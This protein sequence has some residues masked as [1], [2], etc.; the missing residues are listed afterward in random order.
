MP[1]KVKRHKVTQPD[2]P[3]IRYIA[4]T[5]GQVTT[6]DADLYD[7]LIQWNWFAVWDHTTQSFY[8]T[9]KAIVDGKRINLGMHAAIVQPAKGFLPD[10]ANGD[11]L[12]NR[13]LNLR[14]ATPTQNCQNSRL[15]ADNTSGFK[16]VVQRSPT[17]WA[18]RISIDGK[19][20]HLGYRGSPEL[21]SALYCE[22]AAEVAGEF[23]RAS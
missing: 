23:A 12:D 14:P 8:A 10:H 17:R 5:Q 1:R 15:R 19:Q 11:S 16:G 3:A 18:A 21:A 20:K 2:D 7:H 9:R 22:A 13:R 4:L 6:V